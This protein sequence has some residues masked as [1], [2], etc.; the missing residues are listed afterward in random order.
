MVLV[1]TN[2]LVGVLVESS[3]WFEAARELYAR[4]PDW[5]T[6]THA[7]V[8]LSSVFTRL[9]RTGEFEAE[10][11]VATLESTEQLFSDQLIAAPHGDALRVAVAAGVSAY[12]ARFLVVAKLLDMKL[13]TEDARLRRAAPALTQS[14]EQTL[15]R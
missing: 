4:D 8:E 14:L 10:S 12:D 6:E 3:P 13:V 1:D 2:V 9:V 11:A 7:L 15:K 5:Y